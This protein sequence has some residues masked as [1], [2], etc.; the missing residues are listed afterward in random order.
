MKRLRERQAVT[1]AVPTKFGPI[2]VE[3]VVLLTEGEQALLQ[4]R[5]KDG[6]RAKLVD[7]VTVLGFMHDARPIVLRGSA[8]QL[9]P[10]LFTFRVSDGVG[11]RQ[12]RGRSRLRVRVPVTVTVPG[13]A[14]VAGWTI[15]LSRSGAA[16]ELREAP[17]GSEFALE[18]RLP[19]REPIV[20]TARIV[21]ELA[22][23]LA[24]E[25]PHL[26]PE[27]AR[28]LESFILTEK[29]RAVWLAA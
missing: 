29:A 18:L 12:L 7:G 28:E 16:I 11:V 6:V 8:Q 19:E 14:P 20:L 26:P 4:T 3:A 24:V 13:T 15:D 17:G 10:T 25:F 9:T 5:R 22:I 1:L 23:G 27:A 21:R 2:D